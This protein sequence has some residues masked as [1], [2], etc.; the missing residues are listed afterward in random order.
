MTTNV[1][2]TAFFN[3]SIADGVERNESNAVWVPAPGKIMVFSR[4]A[5]VRFHDVET[6]AVGYPNHL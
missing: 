3:S 6:P 5:A 4:R 2:Q 1:E